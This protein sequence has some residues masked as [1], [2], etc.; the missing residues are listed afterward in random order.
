M[1]PHV[2]KLLAL[3]DIGETGLPV[4]SC[5]HVAS[6]EMRTDD[7]PERLSPSS[8]G[9]R[10][11]AVE[12]PGVS[13]RLLLGHVPNEG[14]ER[15]NFLLTCPRA[16]RI[17]PP[18]TRAAIHIE[19]TSAAV[20]LNLFRHSVVLHNIPIG[21]IETGAVHPGD[22]SGVDVHRRGDFQKLDH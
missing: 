6:L 15:T 4:T 22:I 19:A 17:K 8:L 12:A 10:G 20:P 14:W 21:P 2:V 13:R 16:S 9:I 3:L 1:S 7:C 11:C 18:G 5:D